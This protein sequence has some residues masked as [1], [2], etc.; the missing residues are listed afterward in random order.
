M[1]WHSETGYERY[2]IVWQN[3]MIYLY[4]IVCRGGALVRYG[5]I[6]YGMAWSDELWYSM[7]KTIKRWATEVVSC[8][9]IDCLASHGVALCFA[10][11]DI[12]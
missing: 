4:D 5:L 1:L 3:V 2:D 10:L 11:Y 8:S 12:S 6:R 9:V 7:A